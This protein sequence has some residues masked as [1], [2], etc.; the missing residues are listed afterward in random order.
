MDYEFWLSAEASR[1]LL[2]SDRRIRLKMELALERIR[3]MPFAK[4]DFQERAPSG[5]VYEVGCFDEIIVT[6]WVDHAVKEVR[7]IRLET[8]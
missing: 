5:R 4:A 7:I 8:A 1:C 3:A 2:G 6:Y